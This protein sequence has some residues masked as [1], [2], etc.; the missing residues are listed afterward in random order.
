M[1]EPDYDELP[2]DCPLSAFELMMALV[3][4]DGDERRPGHKD[5]A[6]DDGD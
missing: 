6:E 5:A 2:D 3:E 1:S 4:G